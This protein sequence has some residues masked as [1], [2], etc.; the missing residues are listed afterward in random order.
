[1]TTNEILAI[2]PPP[3][4]HMVQQPGGLIVVRDAQGRPVEL[5]TLIEFVQAVTADL[6]AQKNG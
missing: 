1:M 6:V 4:R 3:W 5:F 2:H